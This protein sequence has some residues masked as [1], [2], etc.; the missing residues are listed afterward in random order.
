MLVEAQ[1]TTRGAE[2]A[3]P[4]GLRKGRAGYVPVC[5]SEGNGHGDAKGLGLDAKAA[6]SGWAI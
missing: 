6:G 2:G 5:G 1:H 3:D 4:Q